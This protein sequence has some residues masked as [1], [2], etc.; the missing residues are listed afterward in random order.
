MISEGGAEVSHS[1]NILQGVNKKDFNK[2]IEP[3]KDTAVP[4]SGMFRV[5]NTVLAVQEDNQGQP[6]L[7]DKSGNKHSLSRLQRGGKLT[8]KRG[9]SESHFG[10]IQPKPG[11]QEETLLIG[12]EDIAPEQCVLFCDTG[13]GD[14]II[15]DISKEEDAGGVFFA[16][17]VETSGEKHGRKEGLVLN[18][19]DCGAVISKGKVRG[20]NQDNLIVIGSEKVDTAVRGTEKDVYRQMENLQ[21]MG[22]EV[23]LVLDGMGGHEGGETASQIAGEGVIARLNHE[24]MNNPNLVSNQL[25]LE[26][27]VRNSVDLANKAVGKQSLRGGGTTLT[28]VVKSKDCGLAAN[29]GDSRT[30]LMKNRQLKQITKDH[31]LVQRLV[32]AGQLTPEEAENHPQKNVITRALNGNSRSEVDI[33]P[34][35]FQPGDRILLATDGLTNMVEDKKIERILKKNS[36]CGKAVE[37]LVERANKNGGVDNTAVIIR[38]F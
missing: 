12:D 10:H 15:K 18:T 13:M 11:S 35:D 14:F 20:T 16:P 29:V 9:S 8:M 23:Y 19:P 17:Q 1:I 3:G 36:D 6:W 26:K 37:K 22:L 21:S 32:D 38:R 24:V 2:K 27:A 30:Y 34:L 25:E 33:F 5:G 7:I 4:E 28:M 31:S